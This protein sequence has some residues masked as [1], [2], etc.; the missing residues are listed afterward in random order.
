MPLTWTK[1]LAEEFICINATRH[2]N[3]VLQ[4]DF[5]SPSNMKGSSFKTPRLLDAF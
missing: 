3:P 4:S 2:P 1:A 5:T